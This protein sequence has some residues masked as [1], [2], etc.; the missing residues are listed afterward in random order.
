MLAL[1]VALPRHYEHGH[2]ILNVPVERLGDGHATSQ[3]PLLLGEGSTGRGP[4]SRGSFRPASTRA[5]PEWR[6]GARLL[7][8]HSQE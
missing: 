3:L 1:H 8:K 2:L 7:W 4:G 5:S 6:Q